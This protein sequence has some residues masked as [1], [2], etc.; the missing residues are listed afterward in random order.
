[1]RRELHVRFCEGAGVRFPR[2]TRL[3]VLT[4]NHPDSAHW[5]P[6]VEKRLRE[7]IGKLN[8][9]VNEE[10]TRIVSFMAGEPFD[11]LGYTF[12]WVDPEGSPHSHSHGMG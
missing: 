3:V 5:G 1:M 2:A 7:E 12:R 6:K 9:I 10:K 4:S 11:F 8:L